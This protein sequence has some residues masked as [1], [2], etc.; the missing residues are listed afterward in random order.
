[1]FTYGTLMKGYSN[2]VYCEDAEFVSKATT[3]EKYNLLTFSKTGYPMID[4][5]LT[6]KV[7]TIKGEVYKA[8]DEEVQ[9]IDQLEGIGFLYS[10]NKVKVV[11]ESKE[12]LECWVY[13]GINVK[14]R[15]QFNIQIPDGDWANYTSA[16]KKVD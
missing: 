2:H 6:K 14:D 3:V 5:D 12:E 8:T 13:I 16:Q 10:R 11:T 15:K 1:M 9:N 7:S 4:D